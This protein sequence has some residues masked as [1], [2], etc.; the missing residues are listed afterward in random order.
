[1]LQ[2]G[3]RAHDFGRLPAE[4]L[5][6][7]LSAFNP[8]SIQ[9]ALSKALPGIPDENGF[10]SPGMA[11]SI[12]NAFDRHNIGISVLG[13]YINP[14][15]PDV[16]E[17]AKQLEKFE[18]HLRF[19]RDF[20]CAIVATET[21]SLNPDCS[22]HPGTSGRS[23]FN[24]LCDSL[25][26]LTHV[27]ER[28]GSIVGIEPVADVHTLSSI[29]LVRELLDRID[30]PALG[31]LFDPVNLIPSRGTQ[32]SQPEFFER[33]F[34][35]FGHRIVAIHAKDFRFVDGSKIGNIRA[36]Q[37][38]FDFTGFFRLLQAKKPRIDVILE[39]MS[40]A[41]ATASLKFLNEVMLETQ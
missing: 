20:G 37:G 26:R 40:S 15:H 11:R 30:S 35:V 18:E 33:A 28:C 7:R 6:D 41:T 34:R 39:E 2:F 32:E 23:T 4:D 8:A 9:L 16:E 31:I 24:T 12:K 29:E 3:F 17:R 25:A 13:C 27:A 19:A 22:F 5:A 10:L 14:V 1:M 21:G 36:G 38:D